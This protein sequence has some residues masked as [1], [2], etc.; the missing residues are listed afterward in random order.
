MNLGK[1][2]ISKFLPN[3]LLQISKGLVYSKIQFLFEK[4]FSFNIRPKRPNSHPA[5]WPRVAQQAELAHHAAPPSLPPSLTRAGGSAA[6]SSC[7]A[8]PWPPCYPSPVPWSNPNGRPLLNSV[9]CLYSVVNPPA[10][11]T[12][13]NRCLHGQPL[14]PPQRL[15]LP[16]SPIKAA[17]LT[18][19]SPHPSPLSS[20]L[21]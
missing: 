15:R 17:A 12:A 19:S 3:L 14:K 11:F 1:I 16:P 5:F 8:A 18:R 7:A 6:S 21:L 9:A 4:E 2:P 20:P 13:C 10:L